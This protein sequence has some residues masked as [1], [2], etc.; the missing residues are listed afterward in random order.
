[1]GARAKY[2][3]RGDGLKGKGKAART[4]GPPSL[5]PDVLAA[6]LVWAA[7]ISMARGAISLDTVDIIR[8]LSIPAT[9]AG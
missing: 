9:M 3:A 2:T 5:V 8:S 4:S 1:M 7:L 6:Y